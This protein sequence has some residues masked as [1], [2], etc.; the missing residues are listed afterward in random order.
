MSV[1]DLSAVL[2]DVTRARGLPN[3]HYIDDDVF[4]AERQS[5]LFANWSAVGFAKD[6]PDAGDVS[7]IDFLG[8]PLLLVRDKDGA[9]NVFQ[10]TC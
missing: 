3:A 10:N 2:T 4:A 7:P 6:I 8:M 5:V 9:V 1:G